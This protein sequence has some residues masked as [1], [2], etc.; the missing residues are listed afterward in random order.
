M[1][2]LTSNYL[3][4]HLFRSSGLRGEFWCLVRREEGA[5]EVGDK[6]YDKLTYEYR[7]ER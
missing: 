1:W 4:R 2:S 7:K 5:L 3:E 6:T